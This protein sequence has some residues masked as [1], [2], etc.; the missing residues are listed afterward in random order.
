MTLTVQKVFL[1]AAIILVCIAGAIFATWADW[2]HP[3]AFLAFG[4]AAWLGSQL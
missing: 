2:P 1:I 3:A 4:G